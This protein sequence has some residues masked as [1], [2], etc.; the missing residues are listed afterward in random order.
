MDGTLRR[1]AGEIMMSATVN[2]KFLAK[3]FS[4]AFIAGF[5][6]NMV[7]QAFAD[8]D[9]LS[10]SG[11]WMRIIVASRP[12]AG[13]FTLKNDSSAERKLIG[14]SSPGCGMMMLHRSKTENGVDKMMP[15]KA[16]VVPPHASVRFAPGGYHIMCMHPKAVMKPGK[17]VPVT[18]TFGN[19]ST[20]SAAFTVRGATSE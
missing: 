18:L 17:S 15:V 13:Y 3:L 16:V 1:K 19:G 12:A 10:L 9:G 4:A 5:A 14:A 20:L 7:T 2:N 11:G 8:A 6:L